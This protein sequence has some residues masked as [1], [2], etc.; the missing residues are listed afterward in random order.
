MSVSVF[1]SLVPF[2]DISFYSLDMGACGP[3]GIAVTA[4]LLIVFLSNHQ[5][6]VWGPGLPSILRLAR[7][8]GKLL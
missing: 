6:G 8:R 3:F 5:S 1:Y 4:C 7:Y 2:Y